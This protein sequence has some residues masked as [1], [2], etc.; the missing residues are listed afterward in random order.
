ML[1]K[2]EDEYHKLLEK[3]NVESPNDVDIILNIL[4]KMSRDQLRALS[5]FL[6]PED[7]KLDEETNRMI[8][9]L[10]EKGKDYFRVERNGDDV[11]IEIL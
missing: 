8:E 6:F 9:S 11:V 3:L 4:N 5:H 2:N 10:K 7:S 1:N